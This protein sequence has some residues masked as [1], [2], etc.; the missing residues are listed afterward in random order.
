M[1]RLTK[2]ERKDYIKLHPLCVVCGKP[3]TQVHHIEMV[4]EGG[5]NDESNLQSLCYDCHQDS[6]HARCI[7]R[8]EFVMDEEGSVM[9]K[10]DE[11]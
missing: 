2:K 6:D 7:G 4:I 3:A 11:G 5:S 1:K 10:D 8:L 9:M